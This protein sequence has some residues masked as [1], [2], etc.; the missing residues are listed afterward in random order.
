MSKLSTVKDQG[1]QVNEWIRLAMRIAVSSALHPFEYCKVLIQIG[2]EPIAP[3]YGYTLFGRPAFVLPNIFQYIGYVKATDGLSGCYRGLSPKIMGTLLSLH[4]SEQIADKLGVEKVDEDD[5]PDIENDN[6]QYTNRFRVQLKRDLVVHAAGVIIS[7]PFHVMTIR[8]MAQFVGRE[9]K[10]D[11]LFGSIIQI[12]KDEGIFGFF[13]GLTPRLI[14]DLACVLVASTATYLVGKHYIKDK[15]GRQYFGSFST[16]VTA[17]IFYPLQV[18]AS[19]MAV[20]GSGLK[21]GTPPQMPVYADWRQCY[22]MLKLNGQQK[23]G[24]S[25]FFRYVPVSSNQIKY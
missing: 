7:Q 15:E 18:V 19:C 25:L 10:Y 16:F 5:Y 4:F 12:Y 17:T 14:C 3:R 22:R 21:A 24:S 20:T 1:E 13:S 6:D 9:T 2:F 8:M 23:R 11:S